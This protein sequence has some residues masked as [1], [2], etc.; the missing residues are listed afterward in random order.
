MLFQFLDFDTTALNSH[1][2]GNERG[3]VVSRRVIVVLGG[4]AT[5][6]GRAGRILPDGRNARQAAAPLSG[7]GG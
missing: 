5:I 1:R 3:N 7:G 4:F 2:A 6:L